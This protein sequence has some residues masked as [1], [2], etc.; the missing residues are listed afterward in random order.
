MFGCHP[1]PKAYGITGSI[2]LV[3][4]EGPE[5]V[6]SLAGSFWHRRETVL[7]RAAMWLN[8]RMPEI[9][10]VRAE[11]MDMLNDFEETFDSFTG[12]VIERTDR[13]AD[14]FNGDRNTMEYQGIDP[15]QR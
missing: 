1:M 2:S 14:D 13:R 11:T 9:T 5:V 10:Q 4:L 12:S 15:D 8:A 3:D 6:L 7:G